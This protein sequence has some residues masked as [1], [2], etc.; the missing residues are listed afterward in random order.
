MGVVGAGTKDTMGRHM[1]SASASHTPAGS[2]CS[3]VRLGSVNEDGGD[4]G[5]GIGG[6]ATKPRLSRN[7]SMSHLHLAQY[8]GFAVDLETL[9][10]TYPMEVLPVQLGEKRKRCVLLG[11]CS[12]FI[13]CCNAWD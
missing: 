1:R 10:P 3:R 13:V 11:P 9:V 8:D 5:I 6:A 2:F 12:F 7:G 4:A